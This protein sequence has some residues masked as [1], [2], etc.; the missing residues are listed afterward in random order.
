MAVIIAN[1]S[2]EFCFKDAERKQEKIKVMLAGI[3]GSGKTYSVLKIAK[4]FL[5]ELG[6][7]D[8]TGKIGVIDTENGSS[9]L[10]AGLDG[11]PPFKVLT[12]TPPYTTDRYLKALDLAVRMGFEVVIVDTISHQWRGEGG[13]IDRL[14]REK[15][16]AKGGSFPLWA[17]Y[18]P[19]HTRFVTALLHAP[20]HLF[21]TA[22]CKQSHILVE[23]EKGKMEPK[24]VGMEI[25][26]R[27]QIEYEFTLIMDIEPNH[28]ATVSKDRT[29][30][31]DDSSFIP[32]EGTGKR[33]AEWLKGGKEE[34]VGIEDYKRV[35]SLC[36]V[37]KVPTQQ[38]AE[39]IAK[40]GKKGFKELTRKEFDDLVREVVLLGEK[41]AKKE[42][43]AMD[44]FDE[45]YA[46][47][48]G[49]EPIALGDPNVSTS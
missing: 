22:R 6:V 41:Q 20:V 35:Q 13:I 30:L 14:D 43:D 36:T 10:Y 44:A 33:V 2:N 5:E 26:Q 15:L 18:T 9:N 21:C 16:T 17:K 12:L 48:M 42:Q 38:V 24:K 11:M 45:V 25:I 32:S 47:E 8:L 34:T 31:F 4:G 29:H 49:H 23:N 39:L 1:N 7:K 27:D 19:E 46:A 40:T 3:S 37:H 28:Y